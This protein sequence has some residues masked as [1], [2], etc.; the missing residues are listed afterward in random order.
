MKNNIK[1]RFT[2]AIIVEAVKYANIREAVEKSR[3]NLSRANLFGANLSG[4]K[5]YVN[6]HSFFTQLIKQHKI[7]PDNLWPII[8]K[9]SV[10]QICWNTIANSREEAMQVFQILKTNGF[11]EYADYFE[12]FL[13]E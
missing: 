1:N 11:P 8:G 10:L 5:G 4:A 12:K 6:S 7:F 3:A 9:I 13:K 2:D